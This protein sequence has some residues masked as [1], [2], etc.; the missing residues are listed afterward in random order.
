M[1]KNKHCAPGKVKRLIALLSAG[2]LCANMGSIAPVFAQTEKG[3]ADTGLPVCRTD[4]ST[5]GDWMNRYGTDGYV[6]PAYQEANGER[7]D[8]VHLPS[9]V[10]SVDYGFQDRH[11]RWL[12][13]EGAD[14]KLGLPIGDNNTGNRRLAYIFDDEKLTIKV[15]V[16]DS[17]KHTVSVYSAEEGR[18]LSYQLFK[19]DTK[20]PITDKLVVSDI[21]SG[22]YV[23][24]EF[25]GSVDI[26]VQNENIQH[27]RTN[28]VVSGIFFDTPGS[29]QVKEIAI[30]PADGAFLRTDK[31]NVQMTVKALPFSAAP[32]VVWSIPEGGDVASIDAQGIVHIK[33][34]GSFWVKAAVKN[35][36]AVS[37][38]VHLST[39][40][41]DKPTA[42]PQI[43]V[44]N[45]LATIANTRVRVVFDMNSGRYSAYDSA[46]EQ[47]YVLNAYTEVNGH[48]SIDGYTFTGTEL[49]SKD[50][51]EKTLRLI[52]KKAGSP[53]D[54]VLDISL[55]DGQGEIFLKNGMVNHTS[56]PIQMKDMLPLSADAAHSSGIFVGPDPAKNHTVL[57]GEG[58]WGIPDV[59]NNVSCTSK[60]NLIISYRD[61]PAKESFVMG[62]LTTYEFQS[63]VTTRYSSGCLTNDSRRSI[64][65]HVRLFDSTGKRI[66]PEKLYMGDTAM[67]NFTERNPY[68]ALENYARVQAKAMNV[69]L[70]P[71]D[72]Y[73]YQS[74]WYVEGYAFNKDANKADFAV[75]EAKR[76]KERGLTNYVPL[77]IRLEPDSYVDP[78]EQLWWD[79][80]HWKQFGHL[81]NKYSTI[82][83]W[84]DAMKSYGVT[85]ALYMQPT[86]RCSDYC[87]KFPQQ[88]IG[89][90]AAN[91]ADYTDPAFIEH[92]EKV[93]TNMKNAAIKL[94]FYDYT[95]QI[96]NSNN[97]D[98]VGHMLD[99]KGGFEDPYATAV[100]AYRQMF[101]IPKRVIGN[102]FK[103]VENFWTH[104]GE[105][106]ALGVIDYQRSGT[107]TIKL[108]PSIARNGVYQW[109]R[110][111]TTKIL[112]PDVQ[113]FEEKNIDLRRAQITGSGLMFG[114]PSLGESLL[115]ISDGKLK[116]I[117]RILPMPN[118]GAAPRPVGLFE[119]DTDIPEVY[120]YKYASNNG[121]HLLLLWNYK[122]NTKTMSVDLGEDSAFGGIGLDHDK[123]YEIWDFWD[124]KYVGRY[125]G[126]D[127][128]AQTVRKDE[129]KTLVVREAKEVPY[130][131][132]TNRH[133]LQ[134]TVD[135]HNLSMT[136]KKFTGT[137]DVVAND[138]YKAIIA[139]GDNTKTVDTLT[140]TGGSADA[141]WRLDTFHNVIE[142]TLS[143]KTNQKVDVALTFKTREA[144][145]DTEKP[146]APSHIHVVADDVGN[147][148][149][150]WQ[151]AFDNSGYVEYR[152]Y[153]GTT[154]DFAISS[155]NLVEQTNHLSL[156]DRN[157]PDG[158]WY[159]KIV[160]IDA[161]GNRS[162]IVTAKA[163]VQMVMVPIGDLTATAGSYESAGHND[164]PANVLDNEPKTL[165]H[166]AW[167]GCKPEDR[168]INLH[169]NKPTK[170]NQLQYL[171][172]QDLDNG[173]ITS[174]EVCISTDN[175]KTYKTVKK[176]EWPVDASWKVVDF[177][178]V[179]AT[180]VRLIAVEGKKGF[181]SAAEMRL[182]HAPT[183]DSVELAEEA[184]TLKVGETYHLTAN[185][186]PSIFGDAELLWESSQSNIAEAS[187]DGTVKALAPGKA[188]ITVTS[189]DKKFKATCT[190][191]VT[192][193]T[194]GGDGGSTDVP[195]KPEEGDG[196]AP[197]TGERLYRSLLSLVTLLGAAALVVITKKHSRTIH[198][199]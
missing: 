50:T 117:T 30:A 163:V 2:L 110:H 169:M 122:D 56:T 145:Q 102:D 193:N 33:K 185:V 9:Y 129:M 86:F 142:L 143:S 118:D 167:G 84:S 24:A 93:Y 20:E 55:R 67:L 154:E 127:V 1:Q 26:V 173:V 17:E 48:K 114:K 12:W 131:L 29:A 103:V 8:L 105:D 124:W 34:E 31:W 59:S 96:R 128:L 176:G 83:S 10:E 53:F 119:N 97:T 62:G 172:R 46:T 13:K 66:D 135:A 139:L 108:N 88:M 166:T 39:V 181:G 134:G 82:Q 146:T 35:N 198:S 180:D 184:V 168:W 140:V 174:Y 68:T 144:I 196:N 159:Y 138:E 63:T 104:G 19:A 115:Q 149:L 18:L 123:T 177:P 92:M 7:T 4:M 45:G 94:V 179:E 75:E 5:Q 182:Y 71:F 153:R 89:N 109:Y 189:L 73:L 150:N 126:S 162:E 106:V 170:V 113:I 81:T 43:T 80:A 156:L 152:I 69:R 133:V 27:Q 47:A 14:L 190:I 58:N 22:V 191:T 42:K 130:L 199:A 99:R 186:Y 101:A 147:V 195:D 137:F 21:S 120:D 155:E 15:R 64:D 112:Y 175:G 36:P 52:G 3:K 25:S 51:A 183:M 60:N 141:K 6:L 28:A 121:D 72:E 76:A 136:D 157:V 192:G 111:R 100:S 158:T 161:A 151:P 91:N 57:T 194:D 77:N 38:K 165:W 16:K 125:K 87:Q 74:L 23:S 78:N 132:S 98:I 164:S 90:N 197:S 32:E 160:A 107:D 178:T 61:K 187:K 171:P 85:A 70:S 54:I 79:D 41:F 65:A 116:D 95:N 11:G 40:R 188:V 49:A 37:H 148:S 44:K